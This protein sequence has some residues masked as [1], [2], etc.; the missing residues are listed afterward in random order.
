MKEVILIGYSG[1]AYVVA[2]VLE[3]NHATVTGYLENEEKVNNPFNYRYLGSEKNEMLLQGLFHN[4]SLFV[5]ALGDNVIRERIY[6]TLIKK[7][8]N[9]MNAI[10]PKAIVSNRNDLQDGIFIGAGAILNPFCKIKNGVIINSGAIVEHECIVG[11]FTHIAPGAT[12]AGNVQIGKRSFIGANAI[13]KQ[14]I[15]IGDDVVVGA[16]AV[17]LHN[18]AD[19]TIVVGNPAVKVIK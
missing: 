7:R 6:N 18:V 3:L 12:L 13:V 19:S 2:E 5:V 15:I 8:Y 16:G 17:V 4:K 11:D 14:G 10:H 1:H 9:S